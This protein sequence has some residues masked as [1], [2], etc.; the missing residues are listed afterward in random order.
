M[1]CAQELAVEGVAS[2]AGRRSGSG[3][4]R[5]HRERPARRRRRGR[6]I[7][8]AR[9]FVMALRGSCCCSPL[10]QPVGFSTTVQDRWVGMAG[11]ALR[12]SMATGTLPTAR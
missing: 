9:D 3:R 1:P 8:V 2:A 11:V 12:S 4:S 7:C 6:V 10:I 5:I